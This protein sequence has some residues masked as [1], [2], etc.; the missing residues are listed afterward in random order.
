[1]KKKHRHTAFEPRSRRQLALAACLLHLTV[2][3]GP[4]RAAD[5]DSMPAEELLRRL[6]LLAYPGTEP[7]LGRLEEFQPAGFL[8]Y[9]GNIPSTDTVRAAVRALEEE[10]DWP[11]LYGI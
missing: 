1:M 11:L 4:A 6:L 9:P 8:F 3:P 7:P 10:S 2:M 5:V